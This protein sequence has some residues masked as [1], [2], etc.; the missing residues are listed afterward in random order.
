MSSIEE[1]LQSL[2][3]R[4]GINYSLDR[5]EAP[6]HALGNPH[7]QLKN[8]IHVAGTNGKGSTVAM[9]ATALQLAGH[10]VATFT[11]PHL[12]SYTERFCFGVPCLADKD[13][14]LRPIDE[15]VFEE[16]FHKV[17]DSI[18]TYDV[19]EFELLTFMFFSWVL[20][21]QPDYVFLETGLGGRLDSTNVV[22]P[23]LS[24]ITKIGLDHHTT[25]CK[26]SVRDL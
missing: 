2:Q 10:S 18:S 5:L 1:K 20:D 12:Y 21:K 24:V 6:L 3:R 13:P 17:F 7:T 25:N 26:L 16:L 8:V 9:L 4:G 23:I 19:T 15:T 14:L 11:S 22:T